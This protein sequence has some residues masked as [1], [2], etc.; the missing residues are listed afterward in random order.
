MTDVYLNGKYVG[1]VNNAIEFVDKIRSQRRQNKFSFQTSISYDDVRDCV[2]I[3]SD[4]G[5]VLRPLIVVKNGKSRLTEEHVKKL[6]T[7]ELSWDD[8]VD[9]GIIE[10]LDASE[11][12]NAFVAEIPEELN[13]KHTHLE[14]APFDILGLCGSLVPY[15]N[16]SSGARMAAGAKNQKQ[17]IGIYALNYPIRFDVD[18][19][20]LQ[21]PQK[22]IVAS[23]T[24]E[25]ADFDTHPFGQN[26]VIAIMSYQGYNMED[27][28]VVNRGSVDKGFGR[29]FYYRVESAR[30]IKY[31][32]GLHDRITIPDKD[33]YGYRSEHDYRF[34]EEDGVI[35]P[36]IQVLESDVLV[37]EVSPPRFMS[38][39]EEYELLSEGERESS[40]YMKHGEKGTVDSVIFTEDEEG[41][42]MVVVK[43]RDLKIPEIGDKFTSRHG[44]KGIIGLLVD[45]EDMP[46]SESGIVPD[47][48]FS[49]NSIPT[50]MTISHLIEMIGGKVGSLSGR[51]VDGT[52]FEGESEEDLREELERLGFKDDGTEVMYNPVTGERYEARIF[53]GSMYYL[54]L[55][56]IVSNKIQARARG[57]VQIL[58]RQPTEGRAREGGL[59]LGE[60][61]KDAIVAH[62]A[63][64]VLKERFN[65]DQTVI[66]VCEKCGLVAIYDVVKDK[67]YCPVCGDQSTVSFVETG[68]AFRLFTDELKSL[69]I[70]PRFK[71]SKKV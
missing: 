16:Y 21:Y 33:V 46:F 14:I 26:V 24:E 58:T 54:K 68:Y 57:P 36:E 8:L 7:G 64:A 34:L 3:E 50:R 63:S 62:G 41:N 48:I 47:V 69:L 51:I 1:Y 49:Y 25:L 53:V 28:I 11:E 56:H 71:I 40:V 10:Y 18:V 32:G 66:P 39:G 17:G 61:E 27:A 42:K 9:Q 60:M 6:V 65:A 52:P 2:Y 35:T 12:E 4:R 22:P 44:Q 67:A 31:P 45:P 30:E 70:L 59:R 20:I 23:V 43:V 37:G 13:E 55:K 29:S 15:I 19:H 5:R 38:S